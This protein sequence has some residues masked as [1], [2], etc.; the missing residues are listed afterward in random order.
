[1]ADKKIIAVVGATGAQGGGLVRAI[2][3]DKDSPF[4]VRALTRNVNSDKAKELASMGAEVV[5]ADVDDVESLKQAFTGAYGAFCVTFFWEH[6]SPEK[7]G[8][9]VKAMAQAAKAAGLQHVIWSTLEDTRKWIPLSDDRMPTLMDKYKVPHFDAKGESDT[10]FAE[11]GVPTTC[12][13]T[14]FYWDN[15]IHF[16]S[17][18]TKGPDGNL[19]LNMPMGDKMLPG[20]AVE[21]IGK[22]A[23]GIFQKG[24]EFIGKTVGIAGEHL[25]G[26]EMASAMS[27]ALGQ[28]VSYNAVPFDVFRSLDIPGAADLGNMFQFFHDFE[29]YFCGARSL[30]ETRTLNPAL[31]TFEAWLAQ[32]G[33]RIPLG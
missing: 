1:M 21:D 13:L 3:S 22:S 8:A 17:G 30:D 12:L 26:A 11:F 27:Q 2:L 32:N 7:E 16:G 33:S 31:Q 4:S 9:Q 29:E 24:S 15:F 14:S 10:V 5:Q 19:V 25:T 20:I 6:F 18:P 28:D 23:Y